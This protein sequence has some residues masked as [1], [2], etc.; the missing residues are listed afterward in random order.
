MTAVA[1]EWLAATGLPANVRG[2]ATCCPAQPDQPF[3]GFNL[4][5]HVGD[6]APVVQRN[7]SKLQAAAGLPAQPRWLTQVH[8]T[9]AVNAATAPAAARADAS[10]AREAGVVCAV[11]T[12]DCLPVL[13][14]D[15]AGT[16][17][18]AAHAGWRG[19]SAGV[20]QNV[21]AAYAAAAV[22][23]AELRVWL[24]PAI[25]A[26]HYEVDAVV[27]D[28]FITRQPELSA[29]FSVSRPGHWHCDL[30]H[31]ARVQLAAAGVSAVSGGDLC[32]YSDARL[33]SF[34]RRSPCGRQATLIYRLES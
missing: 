3:G 2:L 22:P 21:I 1:P 19:L 34:R 16:M 5:T 33:Q 31:L 28:A 20:L 23:A 15:A 9:V 25:S 26:A 7:R 10:Y 24:G 18:A 12:A 27:R 11:L 13:F 29:G 14:A 4:A 17:V 8:G 32:T 30:Y 6:S